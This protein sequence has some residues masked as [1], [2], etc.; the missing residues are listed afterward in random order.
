MEYDEELKQHYILDVNNNPV[1]VGDKV[2]FIVKITGGDELRISKV[3]KIT[4]KG[5]EIDKY[6]LC[7]NKID[8]RTQ[9]SIYPRFVKVLRR[10]YE[11]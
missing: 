7:G 10:K 4:N 2:A 8:N 3:Y 5:V 6:D 9:Y 1:Y 11:A